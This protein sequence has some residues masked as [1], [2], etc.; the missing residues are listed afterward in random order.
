MPENLALE[1][2]PGTVVVD[3]GGQNG[4]A[5]VYTAPELDARELEIRLA[6]S[7]WDGTHVA[8]RERRVA[9]GSRWAAFFGPLCRGTYEVRFNDSRRSPAPVLRFEVEPARVTTLKWPSS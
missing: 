2:G 8:V 4:A 5:I 7:P 1:C 3:I 6:G 9:G